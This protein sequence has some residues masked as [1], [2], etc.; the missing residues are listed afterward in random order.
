M[1][2]MQRCRPLQTIYAFICYSPHPP[3][4]K[5]TLEYICSKHIFVYIDYQI[6]EIN[7][8]K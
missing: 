1:P 8:Y 2:V 6:V 5:S 7:K 4:Q 3:Q